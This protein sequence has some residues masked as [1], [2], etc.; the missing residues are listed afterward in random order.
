M[1]NPTSYQ[2]VPKSGSAS[3]TPPQP[4]YARPLAIAAA[5]S[6]ILLAA[7][8]AS[9]VYFA[10][11]ASTQGLYLL[12]SCEDWHN[13]VG[14]LTAE[15]SHPAWINW[16]C[17]PA[18]AVSGPTSRPRGRQP[19]ANN[20][21]SPFS[22][23]TFIKVG[24]NVPPSEP[25]CPQVPAI[26]P[27][28]D[29]I[30]DSVYEDLLGDASAEYKE[31]A[32]GRLAEAV[33]Y[34]TE[35]F[36]DMIEFQ[37]P[38]D[39]RYNQFKEF[40]AFLESSYPSL[41][42]SLSREIIHDFSLLYT[43]E[44]SNP[45]LK[46]M[47][48]AAHYDVVV[49]NNETLSLW[50]E[51]PFSGNVRN[52]FL[53][54]RGAEDDKGSLVAIVEAVELLSAH[55]FKPERTVLLAFGHDEE[56]GG[57]K[58]AG[59]I[60]KHLIEEKGL[61]HGI[62]FIVDEGSGLAEHFGALIAF[63]STGE[64]GSCNAEITVKTRGGHSSAAPPHTGI[65]YLSS[66]IAELEENPFQPQLADWHPLLQTLRCASEHVP[67]FD[68]WFKWALDNLPDSKDALVAVLSEDLDSRYTISTSQA[69][70]LIKGGVKVNALP[71]TVTAT[72]N[73]RIINEDVLTVARRYLEVLSPVAK[74]YGLDL[75]VSGWTLS[76]GRW[77]GGYTGGDGQAGKVEVVVKGMEASPVS[78]VGSW[79]WNV[80][81][82][83]IRAAFDA[84]GKK[85]M[86]VSPG[87]MV[88]NTDT[89]HYWDLSD[90][91][92]RFKP[93]RETFSNAH[94]VNERVNVNVVFTAVRFFY[95]LIRNAAG[96]QSE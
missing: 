91:I 81:E 42:S 14:G 33:S 71:E 78:K 45:D 52:G 11:H 84:D 12:R 24:Q 58:G 2:L 72:V 61:K 55:G 96:P 30:L 88:A 7:A 32:L 93:T 40:I 6:L 63:I 20:N 69:A 19:P 68:P 39:Y 50:D 16:I 13:P 90:A 80:L 48:L 26:F 74:Q 5:L 36:D 79:G 86:I 38:E 65:G 76:G 89:R 47:I 60:A 37:D 17:G 28:A 82:G 43:W 51:P 23:H 70:D 49:V 27:D 9:S 29:P 1:R 75:H 95:Q 92:F 44:G 94:T 87:L 18:P 62:E 3:L 15:Q 73:H 35:S 46:P 31:A 83:S 41:H 8:A 22:F 54:G 59:Y 25:Q 4:S 64:K 57:G 56:I 85:N 21:D 67:D 77:Q 66:L 34:R 53:Y 10:L